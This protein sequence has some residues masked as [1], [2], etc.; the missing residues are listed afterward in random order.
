MFWTPANQQHTKPTD[1][2]IFKHFLV[3]FVHVIDAPAIIM[4][5]M[6][7]LNL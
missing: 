3:L 2:S 1:R 6:P 7:H 5:I 4:T